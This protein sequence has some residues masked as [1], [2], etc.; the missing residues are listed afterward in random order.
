MEENKRKCDMKNSIV[1]ISDDKMSVSLILSKP[2]KN[3]EYTVLDLLNLLESQGVKHGIKREL[4]QLILQQKLYYE[5]YIVAEGK[6]KVDGQDGKYEFY[7]DTD[8]K[9]K[10]TINKDGSID[11]K[12]IQCFV[13]IKKGDLIAKY[14]EATAGTMGFTVTG[15]L[16]K[17]KK[18]KEKPMLKGKGFIY[19][20][21]KT[22]YRAQLSGKIE[23]KQK[24]I[25]YITNVFFVPHNVDLSIGNINFDGDVFINGD[26]FTGF[27][28][29]A[30]GSIFV[31]GCVEACTIK[32][33]KD[34]ILKHGM[35]GAEKGIVEAGRDIMGKFFE[36]AKIKC[37]GN[38]SA[39]AIVNCI[40]EADGT[41]EV[42]GRFGAIVGGNIYGRL[43][44]KATQI[45]NISGIKTVIQTGASKKHRK[46][47][48]ET[49]DKIKETQEKI[50]LYDYIL[51][52]YQKRKE[53][54]VI[55]QTD[56]DDKKEKIDKSKEEAI[57]NLS[58]YE[59]EKVTLKRIIEQGEKSTIRVK[60]TIF[61]GT[62]LSINDKHK[63]A[64]RD[65]ENI[66][67]YLKN[68][69][70]KIYSEK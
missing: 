23:L 27:Q 10:P 53:I 60:R 33:G 25:I 42:V 24:N 43:G 28:V 37:K 6:E 41:I 44:I 20:S 67:V 56:M 63:I 70:I 11:Y 35:Q 57:K 54:G 45:G 68:G 8:K 5:E 62:D 69:S 64:T 66:S 21:M 51:T 17:P 59:T 50:N 40:L 55:A 12:N 34:V 47:F 39:N 30:T 14:Y 52:V 36:A 58:Q 19:N 3:E 4:L 2:E 9:P 15:E 65:Y 38:F 26:I 48:L 7:F 46:Q 16:L 1:S 31:E 18:G 61:N 13:P 29:Q 32:A 22:E 49:Y